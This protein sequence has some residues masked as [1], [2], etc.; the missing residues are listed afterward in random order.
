M[1]RSLPHQFFSRRPIGDRH[2][3]GFGPITW[4]WRNYEVCNCADI[5]RPVN[6]AVHNGLITIND[7]LQWHGSA[8]RPYGAHLPYETTPTIHHAFTN[9]EE[10]DEDMPTPTSTAATVTPRDRP[11]TF[12]CG[13]CRVERSMHHR[14]VGRLETPVTHQGTTTS[15]YYL[16]TSCS[17]RFYYFA[18]FNFSNIS[19]ALPDLAMNRNKRMRW[20]RVNNSLS[21]HDAN[22]AVHLRDLSEYV[23]RAFAYAHCVQSAEGYWFSSTQALTAHEARVHRDAARNMEAYRRQAI[24]IF[25]YHEVNNIRLFGWPSVTPR[26][27]L[28]FGVELEMENHSRRDTAG[29]ELLSSALGGRLDDPKNRFVLARDGSLGQSGLE[30]ITNPYTLDYHTHTFGW[31]ELLSGAIAA[32]G[33]AGKHTTN[34]GMH[35]HVNRAAISP[36][37]LGKALIFVNAD[38]NRALIERIAQ[39]PSNSYTNLRP[40]KMADGRLIATAKYEAMHLT[41]Q[42]VEF[43]IFRGNLRADRVLKNIEFCHSV[44]GYVQTISARYG[45][46]NYRPYLKFL[47]ENAK[48]YPNLVAFLRENDTIAIRKGAPQI[49]ITDEI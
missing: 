11:T 31:K 19:G 27:S 4:L 26:N 14:Q 29:A 48:L 28:C 17:D 8:A 42:T 6:A 34:C 44:F 10:E 3:I 9:N 30:L 18:R 15:L 37:T 16:C 1:P 49:Q 12:V 22:L 5:C 33:C 24:P 35:V 40:K 32:G 45:S 13:C 20:I 46:Y 7:W 43:R 38:I 41:E 2:D 39:R 21:Q 36:L 23:S 47:T 25:G